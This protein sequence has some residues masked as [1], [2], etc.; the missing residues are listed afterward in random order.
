MPGTQLLELLEKL[1][2]RHI[3]AKAIISLHHVLKTLLQTSQIG[4]RACDVCSNWR[5]YFQARA[6]LSLWKCWSVLA[7]GSIV[8]VYPPLYMY[9]YIAIRTLINTSNH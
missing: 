5:K 4:R 7:R 1:L 2:R 9:T 3:T 6:I 8:C